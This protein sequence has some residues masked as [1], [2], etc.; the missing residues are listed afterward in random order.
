MLVCYKFNFKNMLTRKCINFIIYKN[1]EKLKK[2]FEELEKEFLST[3][4]KGEVNWN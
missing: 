4:I 1:V 3:K 2:S